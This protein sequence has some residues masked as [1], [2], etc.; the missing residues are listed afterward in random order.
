MSGARVPRPSR[1]ARGEVRSVYNW[2]RLVRATLQREQLRSSGQ[3]PGG[4]PA[5]G[6]AGAVPPSLVSTN[7][8]HILQAANEIE[9]EDPNVA[10]IL[11]EQAYTMAQNLDPS[12][13]GRGVLQFKTGLMSVIKQKLAKKDGT[14]IDRG[15][16]IDILWEFFVRFKRRHRVDDIQKE[17][18]RLRET[19]TFSTEMGVR[20]VQMKKVYATLKA[21]LDVLAVLAGESAS[22]GVG[23]LV[24]KIRKSDATLGGELMPYNIVPVDAPSLTNAISFFPEV[25]AAI[26]AIGYPS[27][28]PRFSANSQVPQQRNKDMFDLLEFIFGFQKDNIRNQRENVILALANAQVRLGLP[29]ELEPKVDEKAVTEVFRKVLDNYIKWCRYLGTRIAWN[30][31]EALN[32]NRKVILV[33]LYYLI[34]GEAANVRFLPECI[35]YIF[36]HEAASNN[37]G[38][39]AHSAWRNYDDFNEYFWSPSCF[40]LKWPLK[41]ESS[42][43]RKPKKWK[44]TGKTGFVEHRT[45]LHLYRSFHRLWIFLF[46]MFQIKPLVD[47]T[48]VIVELNGLQYSWH[49]L[50]SKGNRNALT[51]LSLWA[52]VFAIYLMDIH[53]WYTLLS[54]LVGGLLGAL[55]RLG[56]I[57]SLDMFHKRFESFPEAFV[58]N[59]VSSQMKRSIPNRLPAQDSKDMDRDHAAKFSPFWN[60]IIKSL[61]EEDYISNREMDLLSIPSNSGTWRLVQWPLFLLTSKI[62]LA[63]DLALDCK[64]TQT[65]LWNRIS[66]DKYMAYAVKEVYYSMERILLS[67][68]DG[69]GRLW[70]EKLFQE[71]NNSISV[72]SLVVT[73]TLKKLQLVLSRFS[74]LAGLLIRDETPELAIGASKAVHE[75]Y[76]VVTH[77]FLTSNLS[78]QLDSWQLLARARNEGRLFSKISWPR[79]RE[80]REQVKRLYLLLTVKDSAT[81]IPKNLEARRRLQF[82]ANSLFMNLPL[83][84]P[85]SEMMPFS[86]FTPYYS[87]TVLYSY[88]DLRVENEDGISILFYLQKIFP[89]RFSMDFV[90]RGSPCLTF[91]VMSGSLPTSIDDEWENFLERIKSTADAVEDNDN[92]ELRFWASYRGQTLARTVRGMMYY[93]RALMLQSYLEKRYLG[94]IEDGYSGADYM[95]TQGYE[96]SPE[97]RARADL[98]FTYV[99]SCQI[100]G[101]QKQKGAQEAADIALLMQRNEALRVA[102]IHVEEN[103]LADGTI[104]KEFYSKL[105][106]ADA[107]GKDQE[108]YSIKLPG[109]P[110]LG[111]GKPENQNHAIIFTRGDAIQTI[112][113]NQDNYLEEAMKIRNLLEEFNGKHD[114]RAPTILGVREHVFTGSVSSLAWFMS[115]QETSFVT[116]G[117]RVLAYPL[118]VRMHYGHPDVFD[119]T[120]HITRGGISKASRVINI[121]EDIYA[122]FNSTL[123][124]GNIT[125]HEYIQVGKGRDVGLNQI[126]LFEGKVAGGNGE[127]VLSR[128]VYRLGQLFDFFRMLSFFFTTVGYYVC[129]MMTVLTVYIFLY[130]RVYLALSGLDSAISTKARMLGNTALDA[131]LNAQFLVQIG[132]FTAVPM[133]MGFILELGLMKAVFS[134]V[135]MQLQLCAVFFTF[136][137]GT[138][139]HY[140]G[141]TILHGGAK[142]KATGR[143]FVVR[144]IKFAEN[145]RLYSRSHFVKALEVALLL[146]VYIAYGYTRNGASSF[147]LLTVS[148]WILV[149]SWLFAPYIFNPS[150]FEWQKTVE[151]FDDWTAWLLYKGGVGIKGENSWESWWDE[152]Q[153]HIQTLRGKILETILSLRFF[154]FQ[155]G[156]VY[157]LHL[158]GDDTS[159]AIYGF[160]WVVL[161]LIVMIFKVFTI[162]P[163]KTQIQ[164]MMRLT[165]GIA[166]IGLIAGLVLVVALTNLTI[167]DLFACVLAIIPTGWGTLCLAITWKGLVQS[168]GLWDSVREIARMYDAGMGMVIFAPVA[169]LS[170]FPFVSTFQSR[171]LFNQAFSRGLEISLIL[172]GNKANFLGPDD[173]A[174]W[175]AVQNVA[176]NV[177]MTRYGLASVTWQKSNARFPCRPCFA[178]YY[179]GLSIEILLFWFTIAFLH[180][181]MVCVCNAI[182]SGLSEAS[183]GKATSATPKV[184]K[185]AR[186][187]STKSDSGSPSPAQKPSSPV[188]KVSPS[189]AKPSSPVPKSRSSLERSPKSAEPKPPIKT[190]TTP[191]KPNRTSKGSELQAKLDAIEE[192]LKKA[193]EQLASAEH[194]KTQTLE[195]LNE[196]NRLANEM[197]E[198]LEAAIVAKKMTEEILEIEKFR[199]DELEQAGIE[200]AQKRE[201]EHQKELES[202]RNQHALD[203]STLL[204]V[205]QELQKVKLELASASNVKNTALSEADDAKKIA[206]VNGEKVEALSREVIHLKSLLD[207]NLDNMNTEAAEMIKKLNVEMNCLEL[208][209]E[210]AKTAE[211]KLPKMESLVEQLRMEVTDARKAESD[212]CEQVEELKK[213]VASFESRL[214]EVNQ[215][216]KSATESLDITRKKMEEYATLLQNAETEIA[217][218]QGKVESMEIEVAKYK[219]DLKESDRKL[220]LTQEE[221][222]SLRKTVELLKS[223][224]KKLEEE[225]LQ[226]LDKDKIAASDIERLLEEKNKLI[227]ELNTSRDEAEK[228]KKAMEGLASALHEMST[229]ARENQERLLAKQAEIEDAQVQIEQLNSAI[230]NTEERYEVMLDEARY[231]IVCLKK[232]VENFETE[233]S[234][235]ST[236]WDTKELHFINAIKKSEDELSSLK[237]E[238][239]KFVDSLKLAEQEA[240]AAKADGIEMLSKLKQAESAATAAYE[241]AEEAKAETLRLKERLLDKENELQSITQENDDLRVRETTALQK[242]KDL[243]SLLEE[244]TAKK[245]EE[246]I[247]LSKSEKEYDILPSMPQEINSR[248]WVLKYHT[249]DQKPN[250]ESRKGNQNDEEEDP[251]DIMSKGL[252]SE[253][254]HDAESIDDDAD[255]KLDS[256]SFD[257]IN[258]MTES[259][260]YGA[261]S[262]TKNQEQKKKKAFLHKFGTLLKKGG[263]KTHK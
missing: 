119:R 91:D 184:S 164:L 107:N 94:G 105:V 57:R 197:N 40:E 77:D 211:E 34:W 218:L 149:I 29:D 16:D 115:N 150:G 257:Q 89:V 192:D 44:R 60:E 175:I 212:A 179:M 237:M 232:S 231:E 170:W 208:E 217:A 64:D 233:A 239:A 219:S 244:A 134:F 169:F 261:T 125:H 15:H 129:T 108:I 6:I 99:V 42:F 22:D 3:G 143:G 50:V 228:V 54:A 191:E 193:R 43:L 63:I 2:E 250:A 203:A 136:S 198:K 61:R 157:K 140:F 138:R 182:R 176:F 209:L 32:K 178:G 188:P 109:D 158:T 223:E 246:K 258:S 122:G 21:L 25:R 132:V 187:G 206:E 252:A 243:S 90:M 161:L 123:R 131:A 185:V 24:R 51:V 201:A 238:M 68:V 84:K 65:D 58:K 259:M 247:K 222:V 229:E 226:A 171:L 196:A 23:R 242:I 19:G 117:Q 11:C 97:S 71:L 9:D 48:K 101:Q 240:Q 128:D 113:M 92:L 262:P 76:D 31:L 180:L 162:S 260:D 194:E 114:L 74:A 146:I 104:S 28:F 56:E 195:E 120:F 79:D 27:E 96:L 245:T 255:S 207:S 227:D 12:S 18:E 142:Y 5:E 256:G 80:T 221:A 98:K 220:D 181:G 67:V 85:V 190:S 205:T 204:S 41:D 130:G 216:E 189:V 124:Q 177:E 106:K 213:D 230:K 72:D 111:E 36:H 75:L 236:E 263:H 116:L 59:L 200:G 248:E 103:A 202:I 26:S 163:K 88:S 38:K 55:G 159:F 37:N 73:I 17:H 20:A 214:K 102:F 81:N 224:L 199:A 249:D 35:C 144:H 46:L 118:K 168:L 145:Y 47:P 165:Q 87:E 127:Q 53:I 215:S 7:I 151:D 183:N 172:A 93:R 225:K 95:S 235:S 141:R 8:D 186:N 148:S 153:S 234:N 14:A 86:V 253:K 160:S 167:P 135:T 251:M 139:T 254:D 174:F 52:P 121:S 66:K 100:Y 154:I 241:A 110:K 62:P 152:E 33:S 133:I 4:R 82:F 49:D 78:E 10:R 173:I 156:I 45:F 210:S 30:S 70:V 39:A 83:P 147:I 69:E 13:A 155:Y 112:D 1:G 137:L 166:A 126:A